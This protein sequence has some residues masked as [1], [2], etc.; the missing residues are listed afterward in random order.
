[1]AL[2]GYDCKM[3]KTNFETIST[4]EEGEQCPSC[5]STAT[6]REDYPKRPPSFKINGAS[7][8]NNYGLRNN[9]KKK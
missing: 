4:K 9:V 7:A 6:V 1:M 5:G 3:C 8:A 2:Y